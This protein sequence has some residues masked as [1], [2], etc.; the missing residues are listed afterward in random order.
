MKEIILKFWIIA[1]QTR[2]KKLNEI[3]DSGLCILKTHN[4]GSMPNMMKSLTLGR[5][6]LQCYMFG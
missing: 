5:E 2:R 4:I 6:N 1:L 3:Q